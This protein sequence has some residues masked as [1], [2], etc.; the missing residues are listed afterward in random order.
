MFD[1]P[2]IFTALAASYVIGATPFGYLAGKWRGM[3]IRKYGSGNIGATNV[4]RV[5]G[6]GIG[7]PVFILDLLKGLL[8]VLA[9]HSMTGGNEVMAIAA[10][11]GAVL[12]HNFTFWLGYK[13]G[14]GV[15]TSAGALVGLLGWAM[16]VLVA[17]WL[18]VF[19]TTRY[20]ALASIVAAVVLPVAAYSQKGWS[21][22]CY[23]TIGLSTLVIWR[24]RS[25]L[26]RL[27][28]GTENRFQRKCERTEKEEIL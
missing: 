6:K 11:L 21:P 16:L 12:G 22:V 14:K 13:G 18:L 3:D 5:L 4:I 10:A 23:F 24:H 20:V 26:Q 1:Q 25:N 28:A 19:Y 8:P 9:I 27:R 2:T 7:I 15:A 17:V